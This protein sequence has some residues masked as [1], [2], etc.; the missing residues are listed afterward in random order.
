MSGFELELDLCDAEK[1]IDGFTS[2]QNFGR[3]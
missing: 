3:L 2:S 1:T